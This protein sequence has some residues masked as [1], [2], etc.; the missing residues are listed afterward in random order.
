M[1]IVKRPSVLRL[2]SYLFQRWI[3]HRTFLL[4]RVGE[5]NLVFK[6]KTQD[7]VG[8]HIYK[9]HAH[10][11]ELSAWLVKNLEPIEGDVFL[12]IG[13][14]IGWYSLIFGRLAK[15]DSLIFAFE[16][17]PL[18]SRLL[19]Q[20][21]ELN[22]VRSV[23]VIEAAVAQSTG[24]SMLYQYNKNNLGRH[25]MLATEGQPS[26][27]VE[28]I[29]LD[30]FWEKRQ[31]GERSVRVL[32]ID[33]EGYEYFAL[34]SGKAVLQKCLLV[35]C[36]YSPDVMRAHGIPPGALVDLLIE[37]GLKPWRLCGEMLEPFEREDLLVT[38]GVIDVIW[39]RDRLDL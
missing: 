37:S 7:V 11:P 34:S 23:E 38:V 17:D 12:D 4:A 9:Y 32:K 27:E 15:T 30:E 28:T 16:P 21:I 19:R 22:G 29:G 25:S 36:E 8:R 31:L 6:V 13:A 5:L 18:N 26:V 1:N 10:E 33:V 24:T 20:N 3:L 14:N 39:T 35:L 2:F